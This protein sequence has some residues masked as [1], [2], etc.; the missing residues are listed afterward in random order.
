VSHH[1]LRA[2]FEMALGG[3]G[4]VLADRLCHACVQLLEVDGASISLM[5]DGASQGTFGS[6]GPL[7]KQLDELQFTLG[8][9]PCVD[10]V[11]QGGPVLVPDLDDPRDQR[12]PLYAGAVVDLGVRAV[13]A[14]PIVLANSYV[15]ALDL[16]R[17]TA[18]PLLGDSLI[19]G[20]LAAELAALPLLDLLSAGTDTDTVTDDENDRG[21]DQLAS[22][23]RV[24]VYQ[25]TGMLMG[26]LG[27]NAPGAL[28]RLRAHAYAHGLTASQVAWAIVER[29]LVLQLDDDHDAD[30]DV[31]RRP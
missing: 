18:G 5:H 21:W 15:G 3:S 17:H 16:Y 10:A 24:E 26:Q 7:A 1:E 25:A 14:L 27:V 19:G 29:R 13:Y 20:L 6:S 23:S 22:L 9:G 11:R 31:G 12:W 2:S 4:S 30:G 28:I 8:V